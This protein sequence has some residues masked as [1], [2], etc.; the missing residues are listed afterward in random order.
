MTLLLV[1]AGMGLLLFGADLLVR[2]A[3]SFSYRYKVSSLVIGLTVVTIGTNIPE[4]VVTV[5]G[6]LYK[7]TEH[8]VSNL[9]VG[10]II[11]SNIGQIALILGLIGLF[12]VMD[13]K[14][15]AL[16]YQAIFL[17]GSSLLLLVFSQ[18]FLLSR[19]EGLIF[20]LAYGLYFI[21]IRNLAKSEVPSR[22]KPS[23]L[24]VDLSELLVG[25]ISIVFGAKLAIDNGVSLA[26][27]LQI[28][29]TI[30]GIFL[31]GMGTSLP[32][33]IVAVTA[34][35][36]KAKG[37]SIGNIIGSNILDTLLALGAGASISGFK[38]DPGLVRFDM[39]FL[40]FL[41]V[42]VI[43]FFYTRKKFERKES[44]LLLTLYFSYVL[45]KVLSPL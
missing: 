4:V 5:T 26:E 23:P 7:V 16:F 2:A 32:E 14:R 24:L 38:I 43:L 44:I 9:V 11:G 3:L 19:L 27:Q 10:Q 25:L 8:S 39:P 22:G 36:K 21:P 13:L 29:Q 31:L 6:A 15:K 41:S 18:D 30:V 34:I 45:V 28:N 40:L 35:S 17:V 33:L 1:L 12:G 42:I 37:I 20:L